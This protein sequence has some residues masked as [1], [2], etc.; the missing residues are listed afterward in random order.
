MRDQ[1]IDATGVMNLFSEADLLVEAIADAIE[2]GDGT[3]DADLFDEGFA[4]TQ[5][6]FSEKEQDTWGCVIDPPQ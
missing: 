4:L 1:A 5:A 3:P 6:N 2:S